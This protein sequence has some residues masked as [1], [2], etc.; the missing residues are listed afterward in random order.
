MSELLSNP[1]AIL[2]VA[3]LGAVILG[4]NLTLFGLWRGN[5][6]VQAEAAKWG[7]A[8]RGGR[9]ARERQNAQ[10]EELHRAV[11]QLPTHPPADPD[12]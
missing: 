10:L 2:I 8:L 9:E 12:E 5:K 7:Q 3:C 6:T 4:L 1:R 11:S